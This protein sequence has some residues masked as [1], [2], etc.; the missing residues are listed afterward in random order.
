MGAPS[1]DRWRSSFSEWFHDVIS[2]AGVADYRYPVKGCGVW[3]PFGFKLRENVLAIMR[4]LLNETGHEE[5]LFPLLIPAEMLRKEAEHIRSFEGQ[6]FWVS[7]AGDRDLGERLALRPTSEAAIAPMLKLWI[8][9]HADLPKKLYQIVSVFRYETKATKPLIRVREV[10]T[11]KEAHTS[12]ATYEEAERQVEEAVGIY[13]RFFDELCVPYLISKR[14]D[15]DKFAGALYS[16]AFDTIFPDGRTLQIGT[17]HNLGQNF[18]RAFEITFETVGGGREF[19]WQ[20]SYGISERVIAALIAI[21]G[22]D[23]GL[24]IPPNIAP[25][26]V[27]Y[28]HLTLP[29]N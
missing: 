17:A 8:R 10:T 22:D 6:T 27:S 24:V 4:R 14:P 19:V 5:V 28:T 13:R 18:S 2:R 20:T 7:K 9:S 11:F 3:L 23:H 16:I 12:H 29:T 15:W 26:P 1:R 21:H 25:V